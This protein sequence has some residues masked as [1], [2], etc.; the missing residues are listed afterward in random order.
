MNLHPRIRW[1]NQ[2][3]WASLSHPTRSDTLEFCLNRRRW[4]WR[5]SGV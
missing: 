2:R 3:F 4:T 5:I 1:E